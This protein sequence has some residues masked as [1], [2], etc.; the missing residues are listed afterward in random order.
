[1]KFADRTGWE[2]APNPLA[3]AL[4]ARRRSGAEVIDLTESN[5][6]RCGFD[7]LE[8]SLLAPLASSPN[9]LYEPDPRGLLAAREAVSKYYATKGADVPPDHILLTAGTSE[10]YAFVLRILASP[11]ESIAVPSP[12]YPLFDFLA[13][14]SDVRVTRY[15]LELRSGRFETNAPSLGE[16]ADARPRALVVVNPNNPTG[17]FASTEERKV[18]NAFAL[19]SRGSLVVDEVFHDYAFD[20]TARPTFAANEEALTFTLSGVSKIVGLPQMKLA[21]IAVSGPKREREEALARLEVIADTFLSVSTPSQRALPMWLAH[22]DAIAG[23]ILRRVLANRKTLA[24]LLS[25]VPSARLLDADGG[26][27]AVVS[28]G[29]ETTDEGLAIALLEERGV[30]V[31]PGYFFDFSDE[32]TRLVVSL[33]P[34]PSVFREGVTRLAEA[35][36]S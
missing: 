9:L 16:L 30:Y 20:G 25:D 13:D 24:G 12:S 14:V 36:S 26:W 31:H 35:L 29:P 32:D 15:R 17:N 8:P 23:E 2:T 34:E 4:E 18:Y 33:L 6:T 7:Y 10:A 3:V 1:M 19:A 28:C 5:P 21:W 11:G 27:Y 22:K